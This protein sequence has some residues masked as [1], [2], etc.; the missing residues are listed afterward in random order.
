MT[1]EVFFENVFLRVESTEEKKGE[2]TYRSFKF[3]DV[4]IL[5]CA[6]N[7]LQFP[8]SSPVINSGDVINS[9]TTIN[10]ISLKKDTGHLFKDA[11]LVGQVSSNPTV[12]LSLKQ[13]N[14]L[15]A[16]T[17]LSNPAFLLKTNYKKLGYFYSSSSTKLSLPISEPTN[18]LLPD[19]FFNF[20]KRANSKLQTLPQQSGVNP[21]KAGQV[22]PSTK[23][24]LPATSSTVWYPK[25]FNTATSSM[26]S[27][28]S[29]GTKSLNNTNYVLKAFFDPRLKIVSVKGASASWENTATLGMTLESNSEQTKFNE[30]I[31]NSFNKRYKLNPR[32]TQTFDLTQINV[33]LTE[34][35]Y[36]NC[37]IQ[38]KF[39]MTAKNTYKKS[40]YLS[41]LL[42]VQA[43]FENTLTHPTLTSLTS[44]KQPAFSNLALSSQM[45][46]LHSLG[47][48][49]VVLLKK[50]TFL[51]LALNP[52]TYASQN[53]FSVAICKVMLGLSPRS[54]GLTQLCWSR[55]VNNYLKN[56]IFD[57]GKIQTG[58][59][60]LQREPHSGSMIVS[61]M[62]FDTIANS[63]LDQPD[64]RQIKTDESVCLQTDW[65][66]LTNSRIS[67][68]VQVSKE[69]LSGPETSIS[70]YQAHSNN[71]EQVSCSKE[72]LLVTDFLGKSKR[73]L[74]KSFFISWYSQERHTIEPLANKEKILSLNHFCEKET[75]IRQLNPTHLVNKNNVGP[76]TLKSFLVAI[77]SSNK[78][79]VF[80]AAQL[81]SASQPKT[82]LSS[83]AF[84]N[85]SRLQPALTLSSKLTLLMNKK[86]KTGLTISKM[87]QNLT[88]SLVGQGWNLPVYGLNSKDLHFFESN[89]NRFTP[90]FVLTTSITRVTKVT[91]I[92]VTT[93][94]VYKNLFLKT[95]QRQDNT[96]SQG[97][98]AKKL[99]GQQESSNRN[100]VANYAWAIKK[101]V[102]K[103][104][105]SLEADWAVQLEFLETTFAQRQLGK[106]SFAGAA[107]VNFNNTVDAQR[108][109]GKYSFAGTGSLPNDTTSNSSTVSSK[110]LPMTR[111]AQI[112]PLTKTADVATVVNLQ[113]GG[114]KTPSP[115]VSKP[116]GSGVNSAKLGTDVAISQELFNLRQKSSLI[117]NGGRLEQQ[118]NS[119][120][121][122]AVIQTAQQCDATYL[123]K[124]ILQRKVAKLAK[125]SGFKMNS[126]EKV[127]QTNTSDIQQTANHLVSALPSSTQLIS[128]KSLYKGEILKT[129]NFN[130]KQLGIN[131]G[132]S[133]ST[134]S[135]QTSQNLR[136]LRTSDQKTFLIGSKKPLVKVGQFVRYGDFLA[137]GVSVPEP[138]LVIQVT[139][140]SITIRL[141]KPVLVSS[142]GV[143]HVQHGDF[144][145]EKAPL[146]TLT[147]SRLK[148]GDIVQGIPKIE[149][150]FE[151]RIS[152][153]LHNQLAL[154][155]ENY[156]QKFSS[157]YA[158]RKSLERI[159]QIIVENV[160][161]VYQ[162]QGV[163]I[164]DKHVEII[165]RQ[166]TS[167]VRI[168]ESGRSGLLRG[169][170]VTLES[171]EN[172]NKSSYGQKAE[173]EPILVGI[174]KA[175]LD[176]DK[177]F[178][179]A[180]SFQETTRIL[181]RA[182]IERKT[183]FL[184]GLKENVILG[185]LIPAGTGFSV[186]FEPEDPNH[187]S[188]VSKLVNQYLFSTPH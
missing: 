80:P 13:Q 14:L 167:K 24:I 25:V 182:A 172:A 156:K 127:G 135:D 42:P 15:P 150:L 141:A 128:E 130:Q 92:P 138:G 155:F 151:A 16:P 124:F 179:S 105:H 137:L 120:N 149:E 86:S 40:S 121:A 139:N 185:Q 6:T 21:V 168:L 52:Q 17:F 59:C 50:L 95:T 2:K 111:M 67:Q 103:H 160:L 123:A 7:S 44:K 107:S 66:Y 26:D 53:N 28:Y 1:G 126:L 27:S 12:L 47:C 166:M 58:R 132:S 39:W 23:N 46:R 56:Y 10:Q 82:V 113:T 37:H 165:V 4:W 61:R 99:I 122:T 129:I 20:E 174:T 74:D 176:I 96:R 147:Y 170:L 77:C 183:D 18:T 158:A 57:F 188:K 48:V 88:P 125:G 109:L 157:A 146:V 68:P 9:S 62:Y 100:A 84:K 90:N 117:T 181:S 102:T 104:L 76:L 101:V 5:S 108:Q 51:C 36:K 55:N 133:D 163:T 73:V 43:N 186:S 89:Q 140:T 162:S 106:N 93:N 41:E 91:E 22:T 142:G 154:I 97:K 31:L 19:I 118:I 175:A 49:K 144:I 180:A 83:K 173:Y 78:F 3:S 81:N 184:R 29:F 64:Q 152:G 72:I 85:E 114:S 60:Y 98:W 30:T 115:L 136:V 94:L 54:A 71:F 65:L 145:E 178:I 79:E 11:T 148:T 8:L 161:N 70:L 75:F 134:T 33:L 34:K 38:Q 63:Q 87:N 110:Y 153:T 116:S 159:Q 32:V 187:S 169:E 177:S 119:F 131:L 69:H 45:S 164:A 171:V 35:S 143:F 112:A